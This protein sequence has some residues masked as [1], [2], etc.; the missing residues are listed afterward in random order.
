MNKLTEI[1][2]KYDESIDRV[3]EEVQE[4][5]EHF[6]GLI[7]ICAN[8]DGTQ[9]LQTSLMSSYQKAALFCLLQSYINDIFREEIR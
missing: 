9:Y 5:K 6:T 2:G 3:L 1:T 4:K 7:V 8:K